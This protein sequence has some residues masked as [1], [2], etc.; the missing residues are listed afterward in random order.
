MSSTPVFPFLTTLVLLPAGGA[1]AAAL[2]PRSLSERTERLVVQAIGLVTTLATL[3]LAIA[4]TIRFKVGD[5][6]YQMTSRHAWAGA[7][8]ISWHLGVDGISLFL[9]LMTAVLFPVALTGGAVRRNPRSF[10]A[11]MLLLEAGCLGSFLS[12]DVI[13]FF[14][15]FDLTL[16]PIYFVITGWGFERRGHAATKF[17]LYTFLGSAF[18]LVAM[19]ALAVIHQRQTG[20]FTFDLTAL[21]HTRLSLTDQ[22]LLFSGFTAA[23]AV[24]APVFPFHTWSPDAYAA[25]PTGGAV[26]LAAVMAKLGTY[27][28]IRFDLTLFPRATLD[29]AP[30]LLTLGVA[31]IIY[32]A[33]VACAQRD[34]KRLVAYSSLGHL[35][36]V[37]IGIFALSTDG[38]A[39]GVLQMV[40]HGI[41]I[42][43]MFLIIGWI[44]ERRGSWN[45]RELRGL[46]RPAP[47]LA[48]VFTVVML[49]AIGLPGLN[50]FVGEFLILLGTFVAHRWW[51]VVATGGVVLSALYLLWAYQQAFHGSPDDAVKETR[52]LSWR[53]GLV[54]APLIVLIVLLGVYPK[55]VLDRITPSVN[56]LVAHVDAATGSHQPGPAVPARPAGYGTVAR[57]AGYGAVARPA[58]QGGHSRRLP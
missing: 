38:L 41:V 36:F 21:A 33:V 12:L 13:L 27:G 10:V 11:W 58:L 8:G 19:V 52:D 37:V 40:N 29:L 23:F 48:A 55:P 18:M 47:V 22:V 45:V 51:A 9:V 26:A 56:A 20:V 32:G 7:L 24:K 6:G 42:A 16:V 3:A 57:P 28:I 30:L 2:V 35:G 44:H 1:L 49:A 25:A 34:L 14:V 53:E 50:G 17:F 54:V 5:G 46:Q 43:A 39:G 31:G 4:V 15:F